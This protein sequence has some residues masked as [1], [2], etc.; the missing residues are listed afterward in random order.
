M[1]QGPP[2]TFHACFAECKGG[3][4]KSLNRPEGCASGPSDAIRIEASS[5]SAT[6]QDQGRRAISSPKVIRVMAENLGKEPKRP[7]LDMLTV[8]VQVLMGI[9]QPPFHGFVD[10]RLQPL[11][12]VWKGEALP[13]LQRQLGRAVER[14]PDQLEFFFGPSRDAI[15]PPIS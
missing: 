5:V 8:D 2:T 13:E 10:S 7:L 9:P 14:N 12:Q 1:I 15:L 3:S 4:S 11:L 6:S